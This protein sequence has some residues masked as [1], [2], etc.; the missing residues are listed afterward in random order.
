MSPRSRNRRGA[1]SARASSART[2]PAPAGVT[3]DGLAGRDGARLPSGPPNRL[4]ESWSRVEIA[5]FKGIHGTHTDEELARF[6]GRSLENVQTLAREL[7]LAKD[8]A[9]LKQQHGPRATRM[10]RWKRSEIRLLKEQY[11]TRAN[12][13][14]ARELSRSVASVVS[15]ARLLG[16]KKS[17]RRLRDMGRENVSVRYSP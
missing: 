1:L 13:E 8:K 17:A 7:R 16:L 3:L 14:L 12:L 11:A 10:P 6:F 2:R 4:Q 9:W 5:L 15:K